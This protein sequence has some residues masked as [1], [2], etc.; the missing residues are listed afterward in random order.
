MARSVEDGRV[1]RALAV[2]PLMSPQLFTVC[3]NPRGTFSALGTTVLQSNCPARTSA[4]SRNAVRLCSKQ[5]WQWLS[6]PG[7][8]RGG[9]EPCVGIIPQKLSKPGGATSGSMDSRFPSFRLLPPLAPQLRPNYNFYSTSWLFPYLCRWH[10]VILC[11][12]SY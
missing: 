8:V 4:R 1:S 5:H 2:V 7:E 12:H 3:P 6:Q 10:E 9:M 11:K